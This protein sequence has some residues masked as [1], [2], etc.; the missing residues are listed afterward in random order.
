M[1]A[2]LVCRARQKDFSHTCIHSRCSL[3]NL[4][5]PVPLNIN[6]QFKQHF[7]CFWVKK[8]DRLIVI[9][10]FIPIAYSIS[11]HHSVVF[12]KR[13]VLAAVALLF[14]RRE[15]S[16]HGSSVHHTASCFYT[17][18]IHRSN[19][20]TS[21]YQPA[22]FWEVRGSQRT[23]HLPKTCWS[24]NLHVSPHISTHIQVCSDWYV[25]VGVTT[26]SESLVI[27]RISL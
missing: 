2:P 5:A 10:V 12:S 9:T 8:A 23:I 21:V 1:P 3:M 22:C 11:I 25:V 18:F 20:Y 16:F 13:L 4:I 17:R 24:V 7:D 6:K 14:M 26:V 15:Y 27:L 19:L